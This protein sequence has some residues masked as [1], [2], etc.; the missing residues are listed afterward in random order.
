MDTNCRKRLHRWIKRFSLSDDIYTDRHITDFCNEIQRRE[1]LKVSFSILDICTEFIKVEEY[2]EFIYIGFPLKDKREKVIPETLKLSMIDKWTPP[3]IILSKKRIEISE[4]YYGARYMNPVASIWYGVD[5]LAEKY[6]TAGGFVYCIENPVKFVDPNGK[7]IVI[8]YYDANGHEQTYS[9]SG[10]QGRRSLKHPKSQFI[11]DFFTAYL[12]MGKKGG[13]KDVILA[14]VSSKYTIHL[15][16]GSRSEIFN[17]ELR[18]PDTENFGSEGQN[19]VRW[20]SRKGLRFGAGSKTNSPAIALEHEFDHAVD[21]A[22]NSSAHRS[23]QGRLSHADK[24]Y[25]DEEYRV[26]VGSRTR[27][28]GEKQTQIATGE[29]IRDTHYGTFYTIISSI[30]R[31]PKRK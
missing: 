18:S 30:S 28:G 13:G 12:Y 10:F 4:D 3:F 11:D 6:P 31:V 2:N 15:Y 26:I 9:F 29:P 17:G 24:Y 5:P 19:I 21:R 20:Q 1:W 27:M 8:H 23:R 16:D 25:N 7:K 22:N 14:A